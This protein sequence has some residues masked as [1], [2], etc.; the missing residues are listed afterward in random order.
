MS[1]SY[2]YALGECLKYAEHYHII[3]ATYKMLWASYSTP[4]LSF[5]IYKM[6]ID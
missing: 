1:C 5:L 4:V 6:W 2:L 3:L